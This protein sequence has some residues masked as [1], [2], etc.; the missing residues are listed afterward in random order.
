VHE[1]RRAGPK[2][3]ANVADMLARAFEED[4]VARYL[5]PEASTRV[6]GL[7]RFFS[8]QLRRS[9][10][11]R[12]EVW[13]EAEL[14]GAALWIPPEPRRPGFGEL[15]VHL[16]L[17]SVLGTRFGAARRLAGQLGARHPARPHYY[18]GTLGT[19]PRWQHQGIATALLEQVLRR[20][21]ASATPAYLESSRFENVAF[22]MARGFSV[23]GEVGIGDGPRLWLMWRPPGG[24]TATP[25]EKGP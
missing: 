17:L 15:R 24:W 4:P 19:E 7:R 11:K 13:V 9:Y 12:G 25:A 22:Y 18:L 16:G 5:F 21:D 3:T 20:C 6:D 1:V 10:M 2:D 8:L 23:V 14:R